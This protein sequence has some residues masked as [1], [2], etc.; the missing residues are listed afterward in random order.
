MNRISHL[1]SELKSSS[2]LKPEDYLE[3]RCLLCDEPFGAEKEV[4]PVPQAR[5]IERMNSFMAM[6]DYDGAERHLLYWLEEARL[7]HDRR[8]ELMIRNE[9]TGHYRK[10][11]DRENSLANA[12]A[13]LDL[14]KALDFEGTLSSGT[15]YVNA[16]TAYNA[17]GEQDRSLELFEKAK[18]IYENE[19]Q[20]DKAL[21]GGLYNNMAL[22]FFSTDRFEEALKF[23][24]KALDAM[25]EVENGRL[26][27]AITYLNMADVYQ[28][29][30]GIEDG[31][32]HIY[33]CLDKA[34]ELLTVGDIPDTGYYA[35]VCEKCAPVFEFYGYFLAASDLVQRSEDAYRENMNQ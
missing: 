4:R 27:M 15:T 9:L 14:I 5:I 10:T 13:A 12:E 7:G 17:F 1:T 32:P 28:R 34:Y 25:S 18:D 35:F 6:R 8:G 2:V 29:S 21:L 30:L 11:G 31:E 24:Q 23:Y 16:A 22:T 20:T 19:G 26:E 33:L 3:P